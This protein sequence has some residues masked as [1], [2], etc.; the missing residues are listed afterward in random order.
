LWGEKH[1]LTHGRRAGLR[2]P[3][4]A[5]SAAGCRRVPSLVLR[6]VGAPIATGRDVW[7][8]SDDS[9]NVLLVHTLPAELFRHKT[10]ELL[11]S[12][13]QQGVLLEV[14][15]EQVRTSDTALQAL[16][17]NARPALAAKHGVLGRPG[18]VTV[19]V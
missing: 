11:G 1:E 12:L 9:G 8:N 18:V 14:L 13:R 3:R 19:E 17:G 5:I 7:E 6:V 4:L 15:A 2:S 10:W 16:A